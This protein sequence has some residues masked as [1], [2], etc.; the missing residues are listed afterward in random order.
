MS[1]LPGTDRE[2]QRQKWL[3]RALRGEAAPHEAALWLAGSA[4][5][6]Q[7]GLRVYQA[8]AAAT[9][10]RALAAAYPTVQQLLGYQAFAALAQALWHA[11]PPALGD[12]AAWGHG[13][14]GYIAAAAPLAGEPYLADVA[15]LDW[16][17]HQAQLVTDDVKAVDG[18]HWLGSADAADLRLRLRTGHAV[19]VSAHPVHTLWAAHRSAAPD[20]FAA[21]RLALGE[22]RSESVRVTRQALAVEATCI[23]PATA[24]FELDLLMGQPLADALTAADPALNFEAWLIDTLQRGALAAVLLQEAAENLPQ[25]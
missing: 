17:L 11:Q 24:A 20:R 8:N 18:L 5:R 12:L 7:Q 10:A 9:A 25:Q 1:Q 23:D 6:Q 2:A 21:A 22:G 13:L 3:L 16:A 19:L 15:R 14:P 4:V